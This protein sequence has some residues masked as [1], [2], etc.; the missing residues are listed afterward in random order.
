MLRKQLLH[1]IAPNR[2]PGCGCALTAFELLCES[3]AEHIVLPDDFYCHGC[4][5]VGCMCFQKPLSYDRAVICGMYAAEGRRAILKLK[6]AS[7][8]NYA[9]FAAQILASRIRK[10]PAQA[11]PD[12]VIP[13][14]MHPTRQR[15]RGYN[16]AALI[17][18]GIAKELAIPCREDVLFRRQ[19]GRIQHTL[20]ARERAFNADS[21]GIHD[22]PL[23]G[24]RIILA[25]DVITTG[26]TMD[27]CAA[28]LRQNGASVVIA[29]AAATAVYSKML[30]EIEFARKLT[31]TNQGGLS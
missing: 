26:S 2:C 22:I 28:L 21:F 20:N 8:T 14:P 25:D 16:Q 19:K 11:L 27:H 7:N 24:M 31:Q 12:C 4:G 30:R 1:L 29:A 5:K 3:C 18:R 6:S 15:R 17:A 10:I 13:I 23:D 9:T